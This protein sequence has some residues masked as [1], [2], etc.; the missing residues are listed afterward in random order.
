[1]IPAS[2]VLL[3]ALLLFTIGLVGLLVRRAGMIA[4]VSSLIMLN[5]VGLAL[6]AVM[7]DPAFTGAQTAGFVL[8]AIMVALAL[9]GAAVLYAFHR[10]RRAVTLDEHDRMRH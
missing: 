5:A 2:H 4:L 6:C 10:F 3:L 1:L 7:A 9:V 8:L